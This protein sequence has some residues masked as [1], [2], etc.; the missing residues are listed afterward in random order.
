ME[1]DTAHD[2]VTP[3]EETVV[4]SSK[5]PSRRRSRRLVM[6]SLV[7]ASVLTLMGLIDIV[8]AEAAGARLFGALVAAIGAIVVAGAIGLLTAQTWARPAAWTGGLLLGALAAHHLILFFFDLWSIAFLDLRLLIFASAL[9]VLTGATLWMVAVQPRA[10]AVTRKASTPSTTSQV[11]KQSLEVTAIVGLAFTGL[12][13]WYT[14][15][16]LPTTRP[17][18]LNLAIEAVSLPATAEPQGGRLPLSFQL[19]AS[20]PGEVRVRVLNGWFNVTGLDTQAS[21]N[22]DRHLDDLI[23]FYQADDASAAPTCQG[24]VALPSCAGGGVRVATSHTLSSSAFPA[25][26][27]W[28]EPGEEL[29]AD[30][31]IMVSE[32]DAHT[33]Q[34]DFDVQIARGERVDSR[35]KR[36]ADHP[37][38]FDDIEPTDSSPG[39]A[40]IGIAEWVVRP[41]STLDRVRRDPVSIL[42]QWRRDD[43]GELFTQ[44][45]VRQREQLWVP[46]TLPADHSTWNDAQSAE[47]LERSDVLLARFAETGV[48]VHTGAEAE[49]LL[50][51]PAGDTP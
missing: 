35:P 45:Q 25:E 51:L 27:T 8:S 1:P 13:F 2:R 22:A 31:V 44:L 3:H 17:P 18:F 28:L 23:G 12:S 46:S 47:Y 10:P 14:T 5:R 40:P 43:L 24:V 49:V 20:N 16:Y 36:S 39:S 15:V 34:I 42:I 37:D 26:G 33:V 9:V 41:Q 32:A 19:T 38:M 11:I 6:A 7:P 48:I 50:R 21:L 29:T 4:A 30:F